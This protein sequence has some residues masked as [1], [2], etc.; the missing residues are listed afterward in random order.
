MRG[1]RS[2]KVGEGEDEKGGEDEKEKADIKGN[3]E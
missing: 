3:V 2:W 1:W